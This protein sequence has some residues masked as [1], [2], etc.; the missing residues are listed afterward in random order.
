[1]SPGNRFVARLELWLKG[2][3]CAGGIEG[4]TELFGNGLKRIEIYSIGADRFHFLR[5]RFSKVAGLP[6]PHI[7]RQE[8]EKDFHSM[9]V[10][11]ID[12]L[13]QAGQSSWKI[14]EQIEL[15]A[16]I[17]AKI[18]INMPDQHGINLAHSLLRLVQK[19]VDG[20]DA[21]FRVIETP[22]PDQHLHLQ[23]NMLSPFQIG[24]CIFC[25]LVAQA[26]PAFGAPCLE[27]VPPF[28]SLG[29]RIRSGE[30]N[31]F[32]RWRFREIHHAADRNKSM[33]GLPLIGR[34]CPDQKQDDADNSKQPLP[35]G[36]EIHN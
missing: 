28:V 1:M 4:L 30:K 14:L 29:W 3:G 13:M 21:F 34:S 18:W 35:S 31:F 7:P 25:A 22:V 12:Q 27:P 32:R 17:D 36:D 33:P 6:G 9:L 23:E 15:I 10:K 11:L 26:G 2:N 24:A 20:I 16:V 5:Q 8:G 19:T